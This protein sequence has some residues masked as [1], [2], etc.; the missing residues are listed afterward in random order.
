MPPAKQVEA[1]DQ[2]PASVR[3]VIAEAPAQFSCVEFAGLMGLLPETELLGILRASIA[4]Y[5]AA[6]EK[7][8]GVSQSADWVLRP[9]RRRRMLR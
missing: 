1:F 7:E 6:C 5:L 9:K 3:Q 4:Q 8:T 2:L